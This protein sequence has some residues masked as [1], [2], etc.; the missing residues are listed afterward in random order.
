MFFYFVPAPT[1]YDVLWAKCNSHKTANIFCLKLELLFIIFGDHQSFSGPLLSFHWI[2]RIQWLKIFAI[3]VKGFEPG[4]SC[5]RVQDAT[6]VPARHMW[7]AESLNWP[8]FMLQWFGRFSEFADF[9]FHLVKL[10]CLKPL[11]TYFLGFKVKV[12]PLACM[13]H[14][15]PT[16]NSTD[17]PLVRRLPISWQSP[18][19]NL[20]HPVT[21]SSNFGSQTRATLY[22]DRRSND[23]RLQLDLLRRYDLF[24]CL[25]Y[26]V[27]FAATNNIN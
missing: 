7:K 24:E 13:V 19:P 14:G 18:V 11:F 15:L 3:R 17:S 1:E 21:F 27:T 9:P 26:P 5:V 12:Y 2:L 23:A 20:L 22:M 16:M 4:T 25:K 8:K 10:H 6:T